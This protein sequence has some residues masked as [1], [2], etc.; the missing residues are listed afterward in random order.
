MHKSDT[1]FLATG[2]QR[3]LEKKSKIVLF[4]SKECEI[5]QTDTKTKNTKTHT[6]IYRLRYIQL[7]A[8]FFQQG[9]KYVLIYICTLVLRSGG[10]YLKASAIPIFN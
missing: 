9:K 10:I 7:C 4:T 1:L 6:F 3:P 5:L 2:Q 8:C